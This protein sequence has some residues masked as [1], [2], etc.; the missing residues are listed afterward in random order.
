MDKK[1]GV[2]VLELARPIDVNGDKLG[3]FKYDLSVLS[4]MDRINIGNYF[5]GNNMAIL[6]PIYDSDYHMAIFAEAVSRLDSSIDT[7]DV[8]RMT[9][10]DSIKAS[11]IVREYILIDVLDKI[12]DEYESSGCFKL[13]V[14]LE[15]ESGEVTSLEYDF[16]AIT[17]EDKIMLKKFAMSLKMTIGVQDYDTDYHLLLFA[18]ACSKANSLIKMRDVL[19]IGIQD[20]MIVSNI[21]KNFFYDTL[22]S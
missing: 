19:K 14:P 5:K 18:K 15:I 4:A 22:E 12:T 20:A 11:D 3:S 1:K 17:C 16:D 13:T 2:G 21:A 6:Q 8:F 10:K 9:A 7:K